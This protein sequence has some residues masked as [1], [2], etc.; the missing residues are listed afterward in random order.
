MKKQ[1]RCSFVPPP[2]VTHWSKSM[3]NAVAPLVTSSGQLGSAATWPKKLDTLICQCGLQRLQQPPER[4]RDGERE[5]LVDCGRAEGWV[6][7]L[8][9]GRQLHQLFYLTWRTQA[10]AFLMPRSACPNQQPHPPGPVLCF[11]GPGTKP[12]LEAP[13]ACLVGEFGESCRT[14]KRVL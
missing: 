5:K 8:A 2:P 9:L 3:P 11:Q 10:T 7:M 6:C 14:G 1:Q 12:K 13:K 4:K